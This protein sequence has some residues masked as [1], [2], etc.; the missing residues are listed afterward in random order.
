MHY[1]VSDRGQVDAQ[2]VCPSGLRIQRHMCQRRVLGDA[3]AQEFNS[4]DRIWA[5]G[6][7]VAATTLADPGCFNPA[8][9]SHRICLDLGGDDALVAGGRDEDVGRAHDGL[10]G[11]DLEALHGGLQRADRIDLGD[12]HSRALAPECLLMPG[13]CLP[14]SNSIVLQKVF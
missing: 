12:D 14:S 8:R 7:C 2:L 3:M 1:S 5:R 11:G 6:G 4:R 9:V 13:L 10:E